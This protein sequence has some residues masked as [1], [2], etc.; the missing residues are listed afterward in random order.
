MSLH[1]PRRPATGRESNRPRVAPLTD[2]KEP[3]PVHAG[4]I[5]LSQ[6]SCRSDHVESGRVIGSQAS[7]ANR[8]GVA[9][10]IALFQG[11][12]RFV[13]GPLWGSELELPDDA[14]IAAN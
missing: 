7:E 4:A 3:R 8:C 11:F 6:G 2:T 12:C 14:D 10:S 5:A 9:T 1:D 13:V